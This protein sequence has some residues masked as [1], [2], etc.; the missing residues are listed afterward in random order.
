MIITNTKNHLPRTPGSHYVKR[1]QQKGYHSTLKA[2]STVSCHINFVC[3]IA[4]RK[5]TVDFHLF[6]I[7]N[8]PYFSYWKR[9]KKPCG[10]Q[11]LAK[12][13][14]EVGS[15]WGGGGGEVPLPPPPPPP[16]QM[17]PLI[18]L[19]TLQEEALTTSASG[20]YPGQGRGGGGGGGGGGIY[21]VHATSSKGKLPI[22]HT[23]DEIVYLSSQNNQGSMR[24]SHFSLFYSS[25]AIFPHFCT[26]YKY[27][28]PSSDS[29]S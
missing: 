21:S 28:F 18:L 15:V 25:Y 11:L 4:V 2:E 26:R 5:F 8:F 14:G 7:I 27:I 20:S 22:S 16:P 9:T 6:D 12:S 24:N 10:L 3:H 19:N 23:L 1:K 17:K 13:W 29:Y